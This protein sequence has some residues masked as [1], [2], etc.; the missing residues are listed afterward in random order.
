MPHLR[1][2]AAAAAVLA[3]A[4]CSRVVT[5]YEPVS[6]QGYYDGAL[7][8]AASKGELHTEVEGDPLGMPKDRFDDFV[9]RTMQG[10]NF[11]P[12]VTYTTRH[13]E[14]TR[15]QY[16]VVML[17]NGPIHLTAD[18]LCA[19]GRPPVRTGPLREGVSLQAAFCEWNHALSQAEGVV[20]DVQGAD[21]P[22]FR[23][24]VRQVTTSLFPV[25]DHLDIG[26]DGDARM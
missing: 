2:Y 4:G 6:Y 5:V 7:E 26:G 15:K 10:A 8:Y 23:E 11:G 18:E 14:R 12:P 3:L 19:E 21:D 20:Y 13:T 1:S 25:Y 16:K 9:T 22:K 17:F 24:L